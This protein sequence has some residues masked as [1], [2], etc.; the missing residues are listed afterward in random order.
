MVLNVHISNQL[1]VVDLSLYNSSPV[2]LD[3]P[4]P[5]RTVLLLCE[6]SV[7]TSYRGYVGGT[8]YDFYDQLAAGKAGA[9]I[10]VS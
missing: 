2:R 8:L 7:N 10:T 6:E 4:H 3:T 1:K 9:E 5:C